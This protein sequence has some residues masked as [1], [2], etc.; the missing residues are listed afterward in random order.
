MD[1]DERLTRD[2]LVACPVQLPGCS[3]TA[4]IDIAEEAVMMAVR[5]ARPAV[6]LG[7]KGA[8]A[9]SRRPGALQQSYIRLA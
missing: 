8:Q 4:R 1:N 9:N 3:N 7:M 2:A 5:R 6:M